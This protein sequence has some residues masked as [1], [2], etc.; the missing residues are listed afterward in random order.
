MIDDEVPGLYSDGPSDGSGGPPVLNLGLSRIPT[1]LAEYLTASAAPSQG[2]REDDPQRWGNARWQQS[3]WKHYH[4][5]GPLR[6]SVSW[7]ANLCSKARLGAAVAIPGRSEPIPLPPTHVASE[8]VA[9]FAGGRAAQVGVIKSLIVYYSVPGIGY[10]VATDRDGFGASSWNV[11]SSDVL[12]LKT[13]AFGGDPSTAVYELQKAPSGGRRGGW[14]VLPDDTLVVKCWRPDEQYYWAPDS[15]TRAALHALDELRRIDAYVD[16]VLSSR[17]ASAGLLL[18]PQGAQFPTA[19]NTGTDQPAGVHPFITEVLDVMVRA[20]QNPGTAAQL[21][22]IPIEIPPDAG[23]VIKH[24]TFDTILSEQVIAL[25]DS[26]LNN[27][28]IAFDLPQEATISDNRGGS[29]SHWG[30]WEISEQAVKIN[31]EPLLELMCSDLTDGYLHPILNA[32][33][34]SIYEEVSLADLGLPPGEDGETSITGRIVMYAD[35]S[36]L[37]IR[38]DRSK[39]AVELYDRGEIDGE[40]LRRETGMSEYDAPSDED[41]KKQ[42]YLKL[43]NSATLGPLALHGLKLLP[44]PI[45]IRSDGKLGDPNAPAPVPGAFLPGGNQPGGARSAD[46]PSNSDPHDLTETGADT[47]GTPS[48][49]REDKP[50]ASRQNGN[51]QRASTIVINNGA[52]PA[53]FTGWGAPSTILLM[54]QVTRRALEKAGNRLRSKYRDQTDLSNCPPEQ[55][56]CCLEGVSPDEANAMLEGAWSNVPGICEDLSLD[57]LEVTAALQAYCLELLCYGKEYSRAGLVHTLEVVLGEPV[58]A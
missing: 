9:E 31:A 56:H 19:G 8:A 57:E 5:T 58:G 34:Y 43:L 32:N 53:S 44:S 22:P 50:D 13:P 21:V 55:A 18:L 28:A 33:G 51:S 20:V 26:A 12:R 47:R 25:R 54:E 39:Q 48:T 17:L 27:F 52:P 45:K 35:T 10:L 4:G 23:D 14:E 29:T 30:R 6:A 46:D 40:A 42:V 49:N 24:I 7:L 11:Y 16:A 38:P 37:A 36:K 1:A 15:P 3:A 41:R 2:T